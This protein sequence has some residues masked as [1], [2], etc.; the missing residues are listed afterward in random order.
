MPG[1]VLRVVSKTR[2]VELLA[3]RGRF[4]P[5]VIHRKGTPRVPGGQALSRSSGF[6]VG[7]SDADG[8]LQRQ[9]RDAVRFIRRHGPDIARMRRSRGFGGLSLD[10]GLYFESTR[11]SP[12]PTYRLPSNLLELAAR[13]KIAI[14]LSFYGFADTPE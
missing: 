14:E 8:D 7:V 3:E 2:N 6:N 10:F 5:L 11:E 1:C 9:A 12:W 4:Q 13:H